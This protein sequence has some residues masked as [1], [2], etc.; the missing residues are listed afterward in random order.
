MFPVRDTA[1]MNHVR[2]WHVLPFP[3]KV[4]SEGLALR[5]YGDGRLAHPWRS[6][7]DLSQIPG[8]KLYYLRRKDQSCFANQLGTLTADC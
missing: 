2:E 1:Q 8:G 7:F 5:I 6:N 3:P 4:H